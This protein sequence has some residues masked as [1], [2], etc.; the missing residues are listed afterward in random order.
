M[1]W[2]SS[3]RLRDIERRLDDHKDIITTQSRQIANL[4]QRE[5]TLLKHFSLV[6]SYNQGMSIRARTKDD[7]VAEKYGHAL[8]Q[9]AG[10]YSGAAQRVRNPFDL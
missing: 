1:P 6:I 3:K 7:E 4:Q 8:C 2:I 10:L 5:A 9:A